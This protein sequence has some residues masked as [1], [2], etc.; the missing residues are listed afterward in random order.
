MCDVDLDAPSTCRAAARGGAGGQRGAMRL[1]I[2]KKQS[3]ELKTL[4]DET[5][6]LIECAKT[7]EQKDELNLLAAKISG[8]LLSPLLPPGG[9]RISLMV[10]LV[11]G[12]IVGCVYWSWWFAFAWPAAATF[13]P[14]IMGEAA[15]LA[16]CFAR[17]YR[18]DD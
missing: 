17:G 12:G 18:G 4:L 10:G 7:A 5:Y 9:L 2:S 8:T 15:F 11:A 14:R 1:Y 16:G 13:S 6:Q 3:E